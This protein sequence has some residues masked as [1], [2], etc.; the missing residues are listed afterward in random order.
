MTHQ[1]H[2]VGQAVRLLGEFRNYDRALADPD[3]VIARVRAPDGTTT[4]YTYGV[5]AALLRLSTGHYSVDVTL[6]ASGQWSFKFEGTGAVTA[7][8]EDFVTV[9][10]TAF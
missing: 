8:D 7:A 3:S 1:T 10:R 5:D 4:V 2:A 9:E 6:T